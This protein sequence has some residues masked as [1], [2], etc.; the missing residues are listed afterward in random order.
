MIKLSV[1]T[2]TYNRPH[3]LGELIHSFEIQKYPKD[4]CELIIVDD[5]GQY[6][7]VSGE[8]W[9]I[10]S[11]PRRLASLGEKRNFCVS[12]T[13]PEFTHIVI[14]DDD[15]IYLPH[16]LEAHAEN[17]RC[18]ARWSFG[19]AAYWSEDNVITQKWHYQFR[20]CLLHPGTA[21][22]KELFWT[23]GGYPHLSGWEDRDFY[24]RLYN[25]G[26]TPTDALG[27][28]YPPFI[29]YRRFTN[30]RHMT[31]VPIEKYQTEFSPIL[32]RT[33]LHVGW[34]RDYINDVREYE[35]RN[36]S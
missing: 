7:D 9:Q 13:S 20:E 8:N 25:Q 23:V 6:G 14:A 21:I 36:G 31:D 16:W 4:Y 3:L 34:I 2:I 18:G 29:I 12:L 27:N 30:E 32:P 5:A 17:F 15:D 35:T 33:P 24:H 26:F 28:Q 10:V 11:F 1:C 19:K 22:D